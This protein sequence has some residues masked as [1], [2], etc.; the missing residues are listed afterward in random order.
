[1]GATSW[2]PGDWNLECNQPKSRDRS[3]DCMVFA[4]FAGQRQTKKLQEPKT[5]GTSILTQVRIEPKD[6]ILVSITAQPAY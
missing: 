2:G 1:M 4:F 6:V 5:P 3:R